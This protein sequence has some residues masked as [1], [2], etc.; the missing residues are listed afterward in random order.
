MS[1][2]PNLFY[3]R[4]SSD[5]KHACELCVR[6]DD[7]IYRVMM[8]SDDQLLNMLRIAADFVAER[9]LLNSIGEDD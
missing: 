8:V 9:G 6:G 4:P 5:G 3:L 2:Q 1:E 7:D